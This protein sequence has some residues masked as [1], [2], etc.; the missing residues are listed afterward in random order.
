MWDLKCAIMPVKCGATGIVTKDVKKNAES[1]P[2]KHSVESLQMVVVLGT[3]LLLWEVLQSETLRMSG[4]RC[5]WFKRSAREIRHVS[6]DKM[7][8]I[9][10]IGRKGM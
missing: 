4:G 8:I 7:V 1:V 2:G 5:C 6:R 9:I 3:S 10:I